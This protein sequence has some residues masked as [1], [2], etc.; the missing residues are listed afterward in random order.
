MTDYLLI[1]SRDLLESNDVAYYLDLA[2]GLVEAGNKV[3]V[4]LVQ[5]VLIFLGAVVFI[6]WLSWGRRHGDSIE[7]CSTKVRGAVGGGKSIT[8][9]FVD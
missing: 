7:S 6:F 5:N 2:R 4:L 9:H 3:T 1:E 8:A